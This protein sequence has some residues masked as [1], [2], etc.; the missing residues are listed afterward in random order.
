MEIKCP[1]CRKL[2]KWEDSYLDVYLCKRC[3]GDLSK[4]FEIV[5]VAK[6]KLNKS[7]YFLSQ[8]N[9]NEA[10]TQA[11]E[12]WNLKH[13]KEA[14]KLAFLASIANKNYSLACSWY[15]RVNC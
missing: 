8:K 6:N 12:S 11:K 13:S 10:L 2:N 15:K 9:A 1:S 14:A 7:E 3:Q 4:L 5:L